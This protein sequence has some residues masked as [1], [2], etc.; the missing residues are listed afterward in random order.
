M[1][2]DVCASVFVCAPSTLKQCV[3]EG[4]FGGQRLASYAC[5]DLIQSRLSLNF[6]DRLRLANELWGVFHLHPSPVLGLYRYHDYD[7]LA[8]KCL[9]GI[10][11]QASQ[12]SLRQCPAEPGLCLPSWRSWEESKEE[13]N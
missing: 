11:I 7:E 8:L 10:H 1:I 2:I 12:A 13:W 3:H 5:F 4:S 6:M 9:L